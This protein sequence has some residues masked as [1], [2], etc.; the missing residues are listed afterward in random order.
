MDADVVSQEQALAAQVPGHDAEPLLLALLAAGGAATAWSTGAHRAPWSASLAVAVLAG[1]AWL[2]R[3]SECATVAEGSSHGQRLARAVMTLAAAAV[4]VGA[5]PGPA[6]LALAWLPAV[7]AVSALVLPPRP[8]AAI[9]L[10]ALAVLAVLAAAA[11]TG[12]HRP[13]AAYVACAICSIAAGLAAGT[14]RAVRESR[15]DG[16]PAPVTSVAQPAQVAAMVGSPAADPAPVEV[17]QA[18]PD[19][20]VRPA[21]PA[22]ISRPADV[23]GTDALLEATARAQERSGVVGGRVGVLVVTP[24]GLG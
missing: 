12:G 1:S 5:H 17:E 22:G 10:G 2:A 9:T 14:L 21:T 16:R 3:G 18:E 24:Q 15:A 13:P 20:P 23:P 19:Q 6:P 7:C 11:G 8:A 4:A